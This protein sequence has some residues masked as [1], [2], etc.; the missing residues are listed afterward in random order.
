MVS[1]NYRQRPA[2]YVQ[3]NMVVEACSRLTPFGPLTDYWY[4]GFGGL[5]YVDFELVRRTLG[6]RRMVSIE[7]NTSDGPRFLF[8]R[9]FAEIDV[10]LGSAS[11]MLPQVDFA[12][13]RIVWLD[14]EQPLDD[15]VLDDSATVAHQ[16]R[17]GS[18]LI[19]TINAEPPRRAEG[20]IKVMRERLGEERVPVD[21]TDD[22]LAR[23]GTAV[24][25]RRVW[26]DTL[27]RVFR[28]RADG[29]YLRQFLNIHY[30]D[31]AQMQTI[32]G[33]VVSDSTARTYELCR[34]EDL[35]FVRE[36]DEALV[37]KVPVLTQR[38][39]LHLNR[40]LPSPIGAH[41]SVDG[42]SEQ[43]AD[44][45]ESFYRWYPATG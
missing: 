45:Y 31:G 40:Q 43:D 8:N 36:G 20:R 10:L 19:V 2:K 3:R 21:V 17:P 34:F 11:A 29:A 14:Y 32:G 35:D 28:D 25:Q 27:I 7:R 1:F 12:G 41:A 42:L 38:E 33:V 6:I 23:W 9:P 15:E 30:A 13:P 4:I 18:V 22:S 24:M 16:L 39:I 44:A 26:T 37:I 5:E